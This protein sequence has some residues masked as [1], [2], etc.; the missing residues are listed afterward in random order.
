MQEYI[1][2]AAIGIKIIAIMF[3]IYSAYALIMALCATYVGR[4][5]PMYRIKYIAFVNFEYRESFYD[6]SLRYNLKEY[7]LPNFMQH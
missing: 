5:R 4:T 7:F 6:S 2:V 1:S 3:V